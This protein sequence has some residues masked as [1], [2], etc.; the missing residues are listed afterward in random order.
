MKKTLLLLTLLCCI[1]TL[2]QTDE[3][4]TAI[5]KFTGSVSPEDVDPYEVERLS[6]YLQR[7]LRINSSDFSDLEKSGLFSAYQAASIID[8]RAR[9]GD[10][11]SF[12]ELAGIDGFGV[13]TVRQIAPFISLESR[14]PVGRRSGVDRKRIN[15]ELSIRGGYRQD[16]E[17]SYMYGTKYRIAS[18]HVSASAGV[19][20]KYDDKRMSP[21]ELTVAIS[22]DHRKG[23][24]VLGDFNAR[25]G[26]GLCLWN[27]SFIGNLSSPSA[28]MRKPSGISPA[29][30]FGGTYAMT[31][32]AADVYEGRWRVSA[33]LAA[34]GIKEVSD[35]IEKVRLQP[36]VNITRICRHGHVSM[37]HAASFSEFWKGYGNFRIPQMK[38]SIDAAFCI[39]GMNLFGETA[40]D[41]VN[42]SIGA[43]L[44]TDFKA[45]DDF[46]MA[47]L[48]RFC[49]ADGFSN[50]YGVALSGE[51]RSGRWMKSRGE[52]VNSRRCVGLFSAD[53]SYHPKSKSKDVTK[54]IQVKTQGNFNCMITDSFQVSCRITERFR[55]WGPT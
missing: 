28:F 34:P 6:D 55:T 42:S 2:A 53:A 18:G 21:S 25:F 4:M 13:E 22:V 26:Q 54:C 14:N 44:G 52:S 16:D 31:G 36:A 33:L 20:R 5:V 17:R 9:H 45:G 37:T 15:Q 29:Y 38:T 11:I 24:I 40:F 50:E 3:G 49:P 32:V 30:S 39:K 19:S 8:Y 48:I 23:K 51:V 1:E 46:R 10:V 7:P 12:T 35:D 41:W 43:V 47:S 27:S